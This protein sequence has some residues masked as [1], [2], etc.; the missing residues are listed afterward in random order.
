MSR[1]RDLFQL[2]Q[3]LRPSFGELPQLPTRRA[4]G[5]GKWF[6]PEQ[7]EE[8]IAERQKEFQRRHEKT[9]KKRFEQCNTVAV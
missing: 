5:L 9:C 7:N 2:H 6:F 4:F 1:Y 8:F 3:L